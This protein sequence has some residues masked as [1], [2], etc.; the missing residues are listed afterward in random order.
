M[1][2]ERPHTSLV[3]L[4]RQLLVIPTLKRIYY[5]TWEETIKRLTTLKERKQL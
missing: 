4:L 2:A 5:Q 3:G 1:P